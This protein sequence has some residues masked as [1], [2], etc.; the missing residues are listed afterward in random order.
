MG[1]PADN[2]LPPRVRAYP[3]GALPSDM[4]DGPVASDPSEESPPAG[5]IRIRRALVGLGLVWLT[6]VSGIGS[7]LAATYG[8]A[9][10]PMY[11]LASAVAAALALAAG[12]GAL[13]TFGYR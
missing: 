12:L 13:R 5:I 2:K 1:A 4:N 3:T 8:L 6:A 7:V 11:L 10:S 9:G